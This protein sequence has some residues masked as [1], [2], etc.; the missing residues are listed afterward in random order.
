MRLG[1][2][3]TVSVGKTSLVKELRKSFLFKNYKFFTERSAYLKSKGVPLN[4][5]STFNGQLVFMAERAKELVHEN[6]ITDRTSI[7]V[8]AFTQA[9]KNISSIE[10]IGIVF[11]LL[12][13]AKQY[14]LIIYIPP[15]IPLVRNGVRSAD[16]K[17]RSLIDELIKRLL[18]H[19]HIADKVYNIQSDNLYTRALEITEMMKNRK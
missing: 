15:T 3:G 11:V 16:A 10:K 14:D 5:E 17:Y 1:M 13:L 8:A 7:D 9:S 12:E 6:F 4:K 18:K 2:V 19:P